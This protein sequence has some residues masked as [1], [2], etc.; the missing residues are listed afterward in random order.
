MNNIFYSYKKTNCKNIYLDL[1]YYLKKEIENGNLKGKLPT[2]RAASNL[3]N[4]SANTIAKA[5]LELE[6][7]KYV[8]SKIGSGFF[9]CY[10]SIFDETNHLNFENEDILLKHYSEDIKFDLISTSPNIS[11]LPVKDIQNSINFILNKYKEKALIQCGPLGSKNLRS[12]I[13]K[14]LL[15]YKI[16]MPLDNIHILSGAQQG[17]DLLS[18]TLILPGDIVVVETPT[19]LGALNTFKKS[20]A[21]IKEIPIL[22]DGICI[23]SLNEILKKHSIKFLY[24]MSNFQTPTGISISYNKKL[25]LLSLAK[26]YGFYILEDDSSADLFYSETHPF[27]LKSLDKNDNVIYIKSFSKIFMPGFRLGFCIVPN[28]LLSN[29]LNFKKLINLDLSTLYQKAF[30]HL[31]DEHLIEK[32]MLLSREKYKKVQNALVNELKIINNINYSIPK[33]GLSLWI[34]LPKNISSKAVYTKLLKNN[35]IIVPGYIYSENFDDYI[36]INYGQI[37]K[38]KIKEAIK[39]LNNAILELQYLNI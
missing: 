27:P 15:S 10:S 36:K 26:K 34:K 39:L 6:K 23:S 38:N 29:F 25:E 7:N 17:I 2:I 33:G 9:I 5:Y 19:Y 4:I 13:K 14:N 1:F 8:E 31:L 35:M 12:S 24:L 16:N 28:S 11:F 22:N 30:A 18:K 21:K 32:Q 20:G 37:K 3:L